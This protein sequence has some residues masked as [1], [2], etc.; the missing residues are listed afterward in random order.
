MICCCAF[1][2]APIITPPETSLPLLSP[3]PSPLPL[4]LTTTSTLMSLSLSSSPS[5]S[6]ALPT[7]TTATNTIGS[8]SI[9]VAAAL[10]EL[11][12]VQCTS[13]RKPLAA[14]KTTSLPLP[15]LSH[16]R[17]TRSV[18]GGAV[19]P[20]STAAASSTAGQTLCWRNTLRRMFQRK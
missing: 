20:S 12:G 2:P 16:K 17:T 15:L 4:Q 8:S 14:T 7:T 10:A 19:T 13:V 11:D 3:L 9:V 5:P 6:Y 18:S 1:A